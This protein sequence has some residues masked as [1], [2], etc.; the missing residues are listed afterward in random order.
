MR[1][2]IIPTSLATEFEGLELIWN[3]QA[4]TRRVDA[5]VLAWVKYEKQL[6]RLF[7]F[8]VFQHPKIGSKQIDDVIAAFVESRNLYPK[9]FMKGISKL[10]GKSVPEL[11]GSSYEELSGH[12]T[13]IKTYR[14]KIMHGQITGQKIASAQLERD[15]LHII[16]WI[17]ELADRAQAEFGYDGL[18]RDTYFA[19]KAT[20][21]VVVQNYPFK[22][23]TELRKWL[24]ALPKES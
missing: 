1:R 8:L 17:T 11:L 7:S 16:R 12:L 22:N 15:V 14:N 18:R 24:K 10:G 5:L 23:T 19:A 9:T 21:T 4:Q 2:L 20:S 13:R 3:S 6:R